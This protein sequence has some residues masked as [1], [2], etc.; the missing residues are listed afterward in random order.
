MN[1]LQQALADIGD[2][3]TKIAAGATFQ[4]LGPWTMATTGAAAFALAIAQTAWPASDATRFI[5]QWLALAAAASLLIGLTMITRAR[6]HHGRLAQPMLINAFE[7][8]MPF[9]AAGAMLCG[10]VVQCAP[11]MA[12]MLPGLWQVLIGLGLFA[13][14]RFLP[15]S[16]VAIAVWY[17][18]SGNAVLL[19][20]SDAR[21]LS[22][23][24]MGIPFGLGQCL[25]AAALLVANSPHNDR[26]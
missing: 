26:P 11:D 2:I 4:G 19:L 20:S 7:H 10:I 16:V 13:C 1:D 24:A 22:P 14:Q 3:R 17:V 6:R 9:A 18:A 21:A 5:A 15:R 23:W 8:F 25:L 12:W